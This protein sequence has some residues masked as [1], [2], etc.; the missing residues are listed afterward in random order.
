[1][2]QFLRDAFFM[3]LGGG[4][5]IVGFTIGMSFAAMGPPSV[6]NFDP[7]DPPILREEVFHIE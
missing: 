3:L 1:M 6:A 5:V 7:Y 4:F 2:K